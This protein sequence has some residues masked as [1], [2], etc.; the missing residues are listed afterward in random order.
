MQVSAGS[1]QGLLSAQLS[2]DE[3]SHDGHWQRVSP[4]APGRHISPGPHA[5]I[6]GTH[7]V[8]LERSHASAPSSSHKQTPSRSSH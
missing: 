1:T 8:K 7:G 2:P 5:G 6:S 4:L 3:P